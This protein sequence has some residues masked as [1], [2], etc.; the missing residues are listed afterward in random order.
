[1]GWASQTRVMEHGGIK[2]VLNWELRGC[3]LDFIMLGDATGLD[4]DD[5]KLSRYSKGIC[6]EIWLNMVTKHPKI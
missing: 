3:W 1:M 5:M 2:F 4:K 6:E